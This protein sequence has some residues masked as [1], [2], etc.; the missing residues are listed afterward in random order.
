MHPPDLLGLPYENM[1]AHLDAIGVGS[2]HASKVYRGLHRLDTPLSRIPN[3]GGH[4]DVIGANSWMAT[5]EVLK[6][7]PSADGTEKLMI[8]LHDGSRVEAV[9]V[10]MHE[11]RRTLC[12]SSQVGCAM[13]CAFCATGTLK[14]S[15]G[16]KAGEI[17]AQVHAARRFAE[18]K[19]LSITRLVFMGMGEPLHHYDET[20][21]ALRVLMDDHGLCMGSRN[22]TVSTVGLKKK[23]RRFAEDFGGRVQ[24]ALSVHA[25]TDATRKQIIP[26]AQGATLAELRQ[27]L[28]DHPR[29]ANRKLMIEYVVL[30]GLNDTEAEMDGLAAFMDGI[31]GVVNLIPFNPFPGVSFR[32]PTREEVWALQEGLKQRGVFATVRWPQGREAHGA[33]GQLALRE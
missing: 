8:G 22:I 26:A 17:V 3:L 24:L 12:V 29:P 20:A 23:M 6:A 7:V 14:L 10:P 15:R 21:K 31:A 25:G 27:V 19:G 32:S 5:A 33:C 16:M 28:L 9:L 30:P 18:S 13:G 1:R 2:R 11:G 4:A